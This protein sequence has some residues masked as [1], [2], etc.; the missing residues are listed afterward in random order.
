MNVI[1]L[2]PEEPG[3]F[4]ELRCRRDLAGLGGRVGMRVAG[5][6][7]RDTLLG[8]ASKDIDIAI[9]SMT[10]GEFARRT[11]LDGH[12]INALFFNLDMLLELQDAGE[13]M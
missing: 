6:W 8:V 5:G 1:H 10:G 11:G 7:V 2:P 4:A 12:T 9:S 13:I 3:L